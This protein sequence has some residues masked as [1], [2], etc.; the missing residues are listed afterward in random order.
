M[1]LSQFLLAKWNEICLNPRD[2]LN[3]WVC[4]TLCMLGFFHDFVVVCWLYFKLKLKKLE[5]GQSMWAHCKY[6]RLHQIAHIMTFFT[7][8]FV[9]KTFSL[10]Q[11][12]CQNEYP[13]PK[14]RS[15]QNNLILYHLTL[16]FDS[17]VILAIIVQNK[18]PFCQKYREE[19][20][21]LLVVSIFLVY[22]TLIID[23]KD[24]AVI[25]N[26]RCNLHHKQ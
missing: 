9:S 21:V 2:Y 20:F 1:P 18:K 4:L 22:L 25:C 13:P 17:N 24:F 26:S 6:M 7:L 19:E 5:G 16:T 3:Q 10:R 11:T 15:W 23:T 14:M 8:D 12:L